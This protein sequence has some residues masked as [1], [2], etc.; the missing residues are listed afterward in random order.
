[1]EKL[2]KLQYVS[3][4]PELPRPMLNPRMIRMAQLAVPLRMSE[5]DSLDWGRSS[6]ATIGRRKEILAALIEHPGPQEVQWLPG[7]D[8]AKRLADITYL[9]EQELVQVYY[10]EIFRDPLQKIAVDDYGQ[11]ELT[12]AQDQAWQCISIRDQKASFG[13]RTDSCISLWCDRFG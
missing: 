13:T 4:R 6:A 7:F 11:H 1:M 2:V 5:I 12:A 10:Q 9:A 3:L 8:K